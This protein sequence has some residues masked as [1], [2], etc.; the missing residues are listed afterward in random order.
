MTPLPP[1]ASPCI[2]HQYH[3]LERVTNATAECYTPKPAPCPVTPYEPPSAIPP[4]AASS[5]EENPFSALNKSCN[6]GVEERK[7]SNRDEGIGDSDTGGSG[8][9]VVGTTSVLAEDFANSKA[10]SKDLGL[11]GG[12]VAVGDPLV[13]SDGE[14][15]EL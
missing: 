11:S 4:A 9:V 8:A 15:I 14:E 3:L 10:A 5:D 2:V 6:R 13:L 1:S 12:A 7:G